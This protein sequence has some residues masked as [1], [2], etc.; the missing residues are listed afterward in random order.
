MV[1]RN[2]AGTHA[3]VAGRVHVPET[4]AEAQRVVAAAPR[5]HALGSRHSFNDAADSP[6]ALIHLGQVPADFVLDA[7][8]RCVTLGAGTP[9][10]A[11]AAWLEA[12]GWALH[13]MGSLP[14]ITVAGATA[15][16]THGS[17]DGNGTLSSAV[18]ALELIRADGSLATVR[19]G[20]D[21]FA[22]M[23]VG[24][25]AFG[26]VSRVSLDIQ[27]SYQL[28]QDSFVGLPWARLIDDLDAVTSAAY[29]VSVMTKWSTPTAGRLWL[30]TRLADGRPATVDARHL[31]ARPESAQHDTLL[32]DDP[33]ERLTPFGGVPG[34]WSARLPHFRF[35]V[36][37]SDAEEIQSEYMLPRATAPEAIRRLRAMGPAIDALLRMTEIRSMAADELW[38]SPAYGDPR[39]ALHFT[40]KKRPAEIAAITRD[41]ED[42][43][44]PLGA[45]PHWGK[46]LHAPAARLAPLYPRLDDFRALATRWDPEGK[47]RN[48]YLARHVF[49]VA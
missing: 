40:W 42:A 25:G 20:E 44:L 31:G 30:K 37:P 1:E 14:H 49:G 12:R 2:W 6:G 22:G 21:G 45:R 13:N 46:L 32:S 41:I 4:I 18:C 33:V 34:P 35:D 23:V 38:L 29:S 3:F 43:L 9:Y 11:L 27:P 10:G 24:L 8:R 39:V 16:G 17:G 28:R 7:E 15:T 26:V 48:A 5:I 19:R 47:F 36:P